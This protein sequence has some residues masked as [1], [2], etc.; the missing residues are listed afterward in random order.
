MVWGFCTKQI[1]KRIGNRVPPPTR[2]SNLARGGVPSMAVIRRPLGNVST[3]R[4]VQACPL[5]IARICELRVSPLPWFIKPTVWRFATLSSPPHP[6]PSSC[7][8][9][10]LILSLLS[11]TL[12]L[13]FLP[14]FPCF[15]S[16][17]SPLPSSR[18][19]LPFPSLCHPD[20]ACQSH[21]IR[22]PQEG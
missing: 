2:V 4:E 20:H 13:G 3:A 8:L 22:D 7:A 12:S 10:F 19:H 6:S 16:S 5:G 9:C 1:T 14:P 15:P 18:H 11:F 17:F 21:A